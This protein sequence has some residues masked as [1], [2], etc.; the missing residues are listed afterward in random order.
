MLLEYT[1]TPYED[2]LYA[3]GAFMVSVFLAAAEYEKSQWTKDRTVLGLDFPNLPYLIDGPIKITQSNA[4]LRHIARKHR[5]CG[6]IE[7]EMVRVDMLENQVMDFRM[8]L[9]RVCHDPDFEKLKPEYLEQLPGQLK[10]FSQF[11]GQRKWFAGKNLTY[12]DFLVYDIL[13]V[14]CMF[15]PKCLDQ[16]Q[17]LKDFLVHVESLPRIAA[18]LNSDRVIS[19]PVFMKMAKWGNKETLAEARNL[20]D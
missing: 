15:E 3:G 10:L 20:E 19:T 6:E 18:F 5:L 9:V 16:F 11:L 14:N 8:S 13:E 1:G 7:E 2:Y 17:N 4:I 12:A